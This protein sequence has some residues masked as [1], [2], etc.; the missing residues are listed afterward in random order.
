L[1][2]AACS[3]SKKSADLT[4]VTSAFCYV[5]LS[6]MHLRFILPAEI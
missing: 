4:M 6:A 1:P 5:D 3:N 2:A